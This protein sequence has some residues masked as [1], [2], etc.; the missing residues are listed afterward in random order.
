MSTD[1]QWHVSVSVV[2]SGVNPNL[3]LE[4]GANDGGT[5]GPSFA[6][7]EARPRSAEGRVCHCGGYTNPRVDPLCCRKF[8][9][10]LHANLYILVLF[11]VPNEQVN[12][13]RGRK[14]TLAPVF[15]LGERS[16]PRFPDRRLSLLLCVSFDTIIIIYFVDDCYHQMALFVVSA[17]MAKKVIQ[18][19]WIVISTRLF[20]CLFHRLKLEFNL[21]YMFTFT[22]KITFYHSYKLYCFIVDYWRKMPQISVPTVHC[23]N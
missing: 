8:F 18:F 6:L 5:E 16:P 1:G 14:D 4:V 17:I 12:F 7:S 20:P 9:E 22:L 19:I 15:L 11:R 21:I 13:W 23:A 3:F 2:F 10:I